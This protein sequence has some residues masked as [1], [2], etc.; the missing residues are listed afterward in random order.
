MGD[1]R[2]EFHATFKMH[3]VEDKLDLGWNNW[4]GGRDDIDRR[5]TDWLENAVA[6]SFAKFDED[7]EK[8]FAQQNEAETD[9]LERAEYD[10]LK[11]KFE[12]K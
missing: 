1:H 6:N 12:P 9:K 4:E 8:Y 5:I 2:F 10:R 7:V 11:A 3:G